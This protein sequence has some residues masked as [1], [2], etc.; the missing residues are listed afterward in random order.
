MYSLRKYSE[1][2]GRRRSIERDKA[3]FG[4]DHHFFPRE[5]PFLDQFLDRLADIA[6]TSHASVIDGRINE[7]DA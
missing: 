6:F 7:I 2:I 4:A 1:R 5:L 3:S